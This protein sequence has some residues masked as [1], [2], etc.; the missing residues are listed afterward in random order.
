MAAARERIRLDQFTIDWLICFI[1]RK[2]RGEQGKDAVIL[3]GMAI[4]SRERQTGVAMFASQRFAR[5]QCPFVVRIIGQ[6]VTLVKSNS[7]CQERGTFMRGFG[8][9]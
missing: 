3:V 2:Q 6:E 5:Y 8:W 9:S 1:I 4:K 7:F